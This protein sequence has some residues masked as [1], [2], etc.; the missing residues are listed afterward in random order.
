[1]KFCPTCKQT[2]ENT[3]ALFCQN[4]GTR[5]VEANAPTTP[6]PVNQ[7]PQFNQSPQPA[8]P[9]PYN[10]PNAA[11]N[12]PPVYQQQQ[13]QRPVTPA[14][15][16]P[17]SLLV[18]FFADHFVPHAGMLSHKTTVPCQPHVKVNSQ[19][20][21]EAAVVAAFWE[22]RNQRLIE[23]HMDVSHGFIFSSTSV[24]ARFLK[25]GAAGGLE[26]DFLELLHASR[27]E[28]KVENIVYRFLHHETEH[29]FATVLSRL[30]DWAI[31]FG[32][33]HAQEK[34][35]FFNHGEL[36][37]APDCHRITALRGVSENLHHRWEEFLHHEHALYEALLHDCHE[38]FTHRA[39]HH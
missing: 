21:A 5:L 25:D 23:L 3:P 38:A 30:T 6:P 18:T 34:H 10:Q 2:Y 36:D 7:P 37:F 13:Q 31:R 27:G 14:Q 8:K 24:G 20:L 17:A 1:M 35:G 4:D 26:Y 19:G 11:P 15:S 16:V 39:A 32:Y 33:G 29:P 12:Q 22:L 9:P 28:V